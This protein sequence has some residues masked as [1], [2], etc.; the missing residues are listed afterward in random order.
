VTRALL[1]PLRAG[2]LRLRLRLRWDVHKKDTKREALLASGKG[3][4]HVGWTATPM[5]AT[6]ADALAARERTRQEWS[7][8][9]R[10]SLRRRREPSS[11]C[12]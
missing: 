1:T 5:T 4:S 11:D 2:L 7:R 10:E 9:W 12:E 3:T 6:G 8:Q